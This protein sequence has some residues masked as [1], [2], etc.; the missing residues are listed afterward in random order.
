MNINEMQNSDFKWFLENYDR[1]FQEYG[2]CFVVI[3]NK[4]ILG[5]YST[6]AEGVSVTKETEQL[7]T[8]IVQECNGDESAY[9]GYISSFNFMN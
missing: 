2:H 9:I 1:I 6:C 8:F 4:R 5:S 7:G 3:K